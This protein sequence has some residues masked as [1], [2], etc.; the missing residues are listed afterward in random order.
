MCRRGASS[1]SPS[2]E[3]REEEEE[4]EREWNR[5]ERDKRRWLVVPASL[6]LA[7]KQKGKKKN[8]AE[9]G[10]FFSLFY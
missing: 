2:R 4:E 9:A 8:E 6:Q 10:C 1:S 7:G 3:G 5:A